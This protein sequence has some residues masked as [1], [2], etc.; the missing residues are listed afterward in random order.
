M[1]EPEQGAELARAR[2]A[3]GRWSS[4]S[5]GAQPVELAR[6]AGWWRAAG[7]A[8]AGVAGRIHRSRSSMVRRR[9]P[10][11]GPA[12]LARRRPAD[13][14][15]RAAGGGAHQGD[16]RQISRRAGRRRRSS[17]G[18]RPAELERRGPVEF[19]RSDLEARRPPPPKL[20]LAAGNHLHSLSLPAATTFRA[21]RVLLQ[22]RASSRRSR[23][24]SPAASACCAA[25]ARSASRCRCSDASKCLLRFQC[26]LRH[27]LW[28]RRRFGG[29]EVVPQIWGKKGRS[30]KV[31]AQLEDTAA[32]I[33]EGKILYFRGSG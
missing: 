31:A 23:A 15:A 4:P 12:K 22:P 6:L 26:L 32:A 17:L 16:G 9:P 33:Q 1:E 2:A 30:W 8:G 29:A 21:L 25:R 28:G 7:G 11:A 13:L 14:A 5:S 27:A 20:E 24:S 10:G 19:A 18:A 3:R